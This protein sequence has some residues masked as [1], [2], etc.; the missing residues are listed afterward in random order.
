M[1]RIR[2]NYREILRLQ[3]KGLSQTDIARSSGSSKRTVNRVLRLASEQGIAWPLAEDQTNDVLSK[4]LST[5]KPAEQTSTERVMPDCKRIAQELKRSGVNKKL[6]WT[7]Y[8]ERCRLQGKMPL[9]YSQFCHYIQQDE[10]CRQ[11]TMHLHHKP[12]E[13]VE[14]DWA[15]DPLYFT[16]SETGERITAHLFVGVLP[17]SQYTFDEAFV[18]EQQHAWLQA[19]VDMYAFFGGVTKILVPDNCKTAVIH[20]KGSWYTPKLN[21][22]YHELA[23]C[24]NTAILPARV[25]HPKDK[26]SAEGSVGFASTW[27]IAALRNEQFFSIEDLNNAVAEKLDTL[28]HRPFQKREGNRWSVFSEEEKAYLAPLPILPYEPAEWTTA[29]V[30]FNYHVTVQGMNYSVPYDY[31]HKEVDVCLTEHSVK[32]YFQ[33]KEIASHPRLHG[34]KGQYSTQAGHMPERHRRYLEWDG[35]RFRAWGRNIGENTEKVV[36]GILTSRVIEQQSYRSCMGLLHLAEK[37]SDLALE[38]ACKQALS[39]AKKPSYNAVKNILAAQ[40]SSG[41]PQASK[42]AH[43]LTRGA[44]YFRRRS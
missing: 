33:H 20:Q 13:K 36:D 44:D 39:Y 21:T 2:P 31:I 29:K 34:P 26:P 35:N 18:N 37:Y 12:G 1:A 6:L 41:N 17:Y 10:A 25:R 30:Q 4:K 42:K 8:L 16:D 9:M 5:Q 32:I 7:E 38:L 3:A 15:G 24:Y 23:E 43:G 28:N 22:S 40:E 19:H 11:V 27:I 14:V